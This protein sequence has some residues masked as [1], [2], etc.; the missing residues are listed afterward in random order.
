MIAR[1]IARASDA[2]AAQCLLAALLQPKRWPRR[3]VDGLERERFV[4]AL[5]RDHARLRPRL[6]AHQRADDAGAVWT[7]VDIIAQKD[8][9][10]RPS[11]SMLFAAG[12]QGR[13]LGQR[14]VNIA[15]R[16]DEALCVHGRTGMRRSMMAIFGRYR[17]VRGQSAHGT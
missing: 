16:V 11:A 8:E 15:D 10:R 13:E 6:E 7:A 17:S 4:I 3:A 1:Q 9:C 2:V 12:D 5:Q 14:T